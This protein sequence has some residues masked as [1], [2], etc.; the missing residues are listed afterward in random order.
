MNNMKKTRNVELVITIQN[1][2]DKAEKIRREMSSKI[3]EATTSLVVNKKVLHLKGMDSVTEADIKEAVISAVEVKTENFEVRVIRPAYE[4]RQN[5]T[6][7]MYKKDTEN[8]INMGTIKIWL[9]KCRVVERKSE[10]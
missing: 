9:V 6:F 1:G 7:K 8:M 5:A 4:G 10:I 2:T 3:P